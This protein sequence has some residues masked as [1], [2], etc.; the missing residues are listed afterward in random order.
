MKQKQH[1]SIHVV[2]LGIAIVLIGGVLGYVLVKNISKKPNTTLGNSSAPVSVAP[3]SSASPPST[4]PSARID[5]NPQNLPYVEFKDWRVR[6]PSTTTYDL[7]R[8]SATG[9]NTAYFISIREL[10]KT[11]STPNTPWIGIIQRFDNP[12]EKQTIGPDA[13][14]TMNQI[15]GSKGGVTIDGKLYYFDTTTQFCTRNTSNPE[16]EQAAKKLESEIK[17][18]ESY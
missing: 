14:K 7:K 18:L 1:G 17:L 8:N 16:I 13:G 2:L 9:D 12:E 4:A 10:A 5:N 11:C 6:F 3:P 15:F